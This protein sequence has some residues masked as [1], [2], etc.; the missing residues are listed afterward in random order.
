MRDL[1][2]LRGTAGLGLGHGE[3]EDLDRGRGVL[4]QP[5]LAHRVRREG[6]DR[7][8]VPGRGHGP[9][10][11]LPRGRLVRPE[12]GEQRERGERVDPQR[13]RHGRESEQ[14]MPVARRFRVLATVDADHAQRGQRQA[15]LLGRGCDRQR[16]GA[17]PVRLGQ[18]AE[19]CR[20]ER[21]GRLRGRGDRRGGQARV[22]GH[23]PGQPQQ[24]PVAHPVRAPAECSGDRACHLDLARVQRPARRR[25]QI[26]PVG[27]EP[28]QR[29][30]VS[31]GA[32]IGRRGLCQVT[33]P[34]STTA[35]GILSWAVISP[36]D[37]AASLVLPTPP[38]PVTVT[39]RL[40]RIAPTSAAT[41]VSR[42]TNGV[43]T[44]NQR[45]GCGTGRGASGSSLR[46]IR[47]C[48][49][50]KAGEGSSPNSAARARRCPARGPR[51]AGSPRRR[52]GRARPV[53][54]APRTAAR[55]RPRR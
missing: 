39:S 2:D 46:R 1:G 15:L 36:S 33:V 42:P 27:Q 30:A 29:R 35:T 11:V 51:R 26:G 47:L 34:S 49:S 8:R 22:A 9:L 23:I 3:P 13:R 40:S 18:V 44:A 28:V 53:R 19:L 38:M 50:C 32:D 25:E 54:A 14:P 5:D 37:S 7:S 55:P 24:L 21:A 12:A 20:L 10:R 41:S 6:P 17:E 48:R 45:G 43:E 16:P 4:P 31:S 52:P